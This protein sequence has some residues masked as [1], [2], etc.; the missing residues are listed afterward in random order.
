[1]KQ[2]CATMLVRFKSGG[3]FGIVRSVGVRVG[4]NLP[5]REYFAARKTAYP[6]RMA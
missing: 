2:S 5:L 4:F 3:I 6:S 1:M